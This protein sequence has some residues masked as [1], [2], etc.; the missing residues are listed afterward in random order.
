MWILGLKGMGIEHLLHVGRSS[1]SIFLL[2][3]GVKDGAVVR[4]LASH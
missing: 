4:A 3:L 1:Y 2:Y